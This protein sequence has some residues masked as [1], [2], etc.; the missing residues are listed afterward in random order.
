MRVKLSVAQLISSSATPEQRKP[1]NCSYN[2]GAGN[3]GNGMSEYAFCSADLTK[4]E[5]SIGTEMCRDYIFENGV[6]K[7]TTT[8]YP[9]GVCFAE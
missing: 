4:P 8:A 9:C 1:L 2:N 6:K 7:Y 5:G 3:A